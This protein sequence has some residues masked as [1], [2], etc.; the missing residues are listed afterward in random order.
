MTTSVLNRR[1]FL[2]SSVAGSAGLCI[3]FYLPAA[4]FSDPAVD[5]E[6]K[7]P[8]PFNAWVHIP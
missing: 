4:A 7:T 8:N 1:D 3:G 6:K 5:Q 2:K